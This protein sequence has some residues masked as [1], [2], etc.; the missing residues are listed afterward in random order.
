MGLLYMP[1]SEQL[2]EYTLLDTETRQNYEYDPLD[3]FSRLP[4][5][6]RFH[7]CKVVRL[8][9]KIHSATVLDFLRLLLMNKYPFLKFIMLHTVIM[10]INFKNEEIVA[11][12]TENG[13]Q[14]LIWEEPSLRTKGRIV[15]R[16]HMN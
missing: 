16:M 10:P 15:H 4:M 8:R 13:P 9:G 6:Q 5:G 12:A 1:F 3:C 14:S 2:Q 7:F 11:F